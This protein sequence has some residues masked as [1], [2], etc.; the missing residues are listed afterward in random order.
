VS[1]IWLFNV[2]SGGPSLG[3][4]TCQTYRASVLSPQLLSYF[5]MHIAR[6]PDRNS[7]KGK[8]DFCSRFHKDFSWSGQRRPG[9]RESLEVP[10]AVMN[11]TWEGNSSFQRMYPGHVL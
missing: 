11:T 4:P 3:C 2:G 1:A 9:V 7:L 10:I 6:M 5:F 8:V